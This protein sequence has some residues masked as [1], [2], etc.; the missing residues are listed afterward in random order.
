MIDWKT[1]DDPEDVFGPDHAL[2]Q[3]IYA[4]AV[5]SRSEAAAECECL[6]VHLDEAGT[7]LERRSFS[8]AERDDLADRIASAI[9]AC[10]QMPAVPAANGEPLPFCRD[11]PG[12]GGLC[13]GLSRGVLATTPH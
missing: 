9:E 10:V 4:L 13:P 1:G 12:A 6:W 2:Q 7:R 3:E 11:C 5:L 8:A